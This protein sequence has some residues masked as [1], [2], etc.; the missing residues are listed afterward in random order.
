MLNKLALLVINLY[1]KIPYRLGCCRFHPTCSGYGKEAYEKYGF[2]KA[3]WLT[4]WRILRCNPFNKN[5]GN[6]PLE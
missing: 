2:F 3:T 1:R 4:V 5:C 6:D